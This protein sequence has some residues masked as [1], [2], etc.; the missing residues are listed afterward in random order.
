MNPKSTVEIASNAVVQDIMR[1]LA[2]RLDMHWDSLTE[3]EDSED[4]N[5]IHEPPRRVFIPISNTE[6][7]VSDYLFPG[8]SS[9]DLLAPLKDLLGISSVNLK[10]V[11]DIEG[12]AG[13]EMHQ[14]KNSSFILT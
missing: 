12:Q 3:E 6:L 11:E 13:R 9:P 4:I 14:N 7:T 1:S 10:D 2:S 8:E 5:T